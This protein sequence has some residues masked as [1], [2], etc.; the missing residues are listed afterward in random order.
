MIL[1]WAAQLPVVLIG[2]LVL[3]VPGVL[4][5]SGVGIRGLA[6]FAAAPVF[7]TLATASAAIV[8]SWLGVP[9]SPLTWA[10]AIVIISAVA[11]AV[12]RWLGKPVH[13]AA[14]G[15][16][17]ALLIGAIVFAVIITTWRLAA[18]IGDPDAISQTNDAVFHLNAV[19]YIL[20][21]SDA[22]SLRVSSFI[23]GTGFYPGA[24]HAVVSLIVLCT[25]TSIP[26]AANAFTLLIGAVI[27]PL[28]I[29]WLV[30]LVTGSSTI[31]AYAAVLAGVM[32]NFPLLMF[33]WGVL[34]PNALSTALVPAAIAL[35]L[36]LPGWNKS[37]TPARVAVRSVLVIVVAAGALAVSQP[38]ALLPWGAISLV[39]LT[40]RTVASAASRRRWTV[41][42]AL[43]GLW[44]CLGLVWLVLSRSTS[45]SHW[46]F[47]R[48][49]LEAVLD[50]FVNSQVLI[51]P[52]IGISILMMIGIFVAARQPSL[53]WLA[54]AWVGVS[55]VYWLVAAVGN[56]TVRDV[57]LGAWYADP[58]RI[59]A[60]VPVVVVPLAAIGVDAVVRAVT[61]RTRGATTTTV[62]VVIVTL[63]V[64]ATVLVLV[65]P[66][67][68]PSISSL[69]YNNV[70]RY[71]SS[72]KSFLSND[73][74]T[75]LEELPALI[76]PG[77][78]VLGNPSTGSGFGYFFSGVDVY[79]RT[80]SPPPD[81]E[82]QVLAEDL[83]EVADDA[84]VC[85]ALGTFGNATYV[86][87]FGPG[88]STPGRWEMP[89]MTDFA[90][91]D[92]FELVAEEG[93]ASLWRITACDQ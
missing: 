61:S 41:W 81:P 87:D 84:A 68:L 6:L 49:R 20:E 9:W 46:P 74:R 11:W 32:Q 39:W 17:R 25:G 21:T 40:F 12:G 34:F 83:R 33:Q 15:G 65:R 43:G 26:I 79:P 31:A 63:A 18:Y 7:G 29:S 77:S 1:D 80:W 44:A 16:P 23:G 13:E 91:Q 22:S 45:G 71:E 56:E 72:E 28:G 53:R 70:S 75:L 47:F 59:A 67:P 73:E 51:A 2:L 36:A 57:V 64:L 78:R 82:W 66:T 60:I 93:D 54:I 86:L 19:R 8:L 69:T 88:A 14:S 5:L 37:A 35:I 30:R 27:W 92:G 52:Q 76:E 50:I 90:G 42:A 58:Y 3:V 89:G 10:L 55:G 24:W 85:E 62:T 4:A 38:S 48:T